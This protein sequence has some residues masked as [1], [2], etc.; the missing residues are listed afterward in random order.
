MAN[1]SD[2]SQGTKNQE[3]IRERSRAER[4]VSDTIGTLRVCIRPKLKVLTNYSIDFDEEEHAGFYEIATDTLQGVLNQ[5]NVIIADLCEAIGEE[6]E[7]QERQSD[8]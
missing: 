1:K 7:P 5:T 4:A 6:P 3:S 8:E 2:T